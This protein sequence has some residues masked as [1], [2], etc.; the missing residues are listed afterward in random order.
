MELKMWTDGDGEQRIEPIVPVPDKPSELIRLAIADLKKTAAMPDDYTIDMHQWHGKDWQNEKKCSVCFAGS[1]MA[2][3]LQAP[4]GLSLS[5]S[6][7]DTHWEYAFA[8]LD[9]V[10][11][12][13]VIP[14]L[15]DYPADHEYN[16]YNLPQSIAKDIRC[17]DR[18]TF[19]ENPDMFCKDMELIA[20]LFERHGK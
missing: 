5:N 11:Q 6:A 9:Q 15:A 3:T 12:Y 17:M 16:R 18:H 7:F 1:V 13:V 19:G 8:F 20:Y 10:R 2:Q 4:R 14:L